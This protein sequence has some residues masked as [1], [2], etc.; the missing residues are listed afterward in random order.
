MNQNVQFFMRNTI[1]A[2][3]IYLASGGSPIVCQELVPKGVIF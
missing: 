1:I 3:F 2:I